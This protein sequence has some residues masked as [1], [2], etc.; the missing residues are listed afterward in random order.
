MSSS[1]LYGKVV[2]ITG[3]ARGL[4]KGFAEAVL[5]SGG[6]VT[7]CDVLE[8]VGKETVKEFGSRFGKDKVGGV[9]STLIGT[10][11]ET[12]AAQ[13]MKSSFNHQFR[14]FGIDAM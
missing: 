7:V 12:G 14:S 8:D 6:K 11:L 2:I 13:P 4:G 9:V 10:L 5:V 3:S 1:S